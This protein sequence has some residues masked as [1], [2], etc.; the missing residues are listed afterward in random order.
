M[1]TVRNLLP[2]SF[3][4]QSRATVPVR[5]AAPQLYA[6]IASDCFAVGSKCCW[7]AFLHQEACL[8]S[9]GAM[10][11]GDEQETQRSVMHLQN[12]TARK[13]HATPA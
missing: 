13:T 6:A 4:T 12:R 10:Q 8:S 2:H 5:A 9:E 1:N 7:E 11:I 3:Y